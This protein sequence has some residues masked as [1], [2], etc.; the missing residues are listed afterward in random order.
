MDTRIRRQ[1]GQ[2]EGAL[3]RRCWRVRDESAPAP[4]AAP[5]AH[6]AGSSSVPKGSSIPGRFPLRVGPRTRT[7]ASE[8][9]HDS[10]EAKRREKKRSQVHPPT[11]ELM[12]VSTD[13]GAG[14]ISR[15]S[16]FGGTWTARRRWP[17]Y[18][19]WPR[20][21]RAGERLPEALAGVLRHRVGGGR[22]PCP[23][24]P[25]T[26]L[27]DA[28]KAAHAVLNTAAGKGVTPPP[29]DPLAFRAARGAADGR[30]RPRPEPRCRCGR[31]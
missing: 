3:N 19:R 1:A 12:P 26:G 20:F 16:G 29:L 22:R 10:N 25:V 4:T 13:A 18:H 2:E 17:P 21:A 8:G 30:G 5:G 27:S 23:D 9:E 31:A 15:R 11:A 6:R 24:T 7:L 28:A 14:G